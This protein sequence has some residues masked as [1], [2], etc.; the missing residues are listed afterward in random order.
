VRSVAS[1]RPA[2]PAPAKALEFPAQELKPIR[3]ILD[4]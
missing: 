1:T 3:I 4:K 2:G